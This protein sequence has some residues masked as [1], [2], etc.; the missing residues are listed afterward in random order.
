M[1]ILRCGRGEFKVEVVERPESVRAQWKSW[2]DG[3][4]T[5]VNADNVGGARREMQ[6]EIA[7]SV[8]TPFKTSMTYELCFG[9]RTFILE[10]RPRN[11]APSSVLRCYI[12]NE[13]TIRS[14]RSS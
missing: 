12:A 14:D 11:I 7:R 2:G 10:L 3:G 8:I 1:A 13:T 5:P 9:L 6:C 4:C